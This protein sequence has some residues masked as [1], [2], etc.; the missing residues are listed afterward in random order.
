MAGWPL[1]AGT[2]SGPTTAATDGSSGGAEV[3]RSRSSGWAI[4][5]TYGARAGPSGAAGVPG[6]PATPEPAD[7]ASAIEPAAAADAAASSGDRSA[8]AERSQ[9]PP[10]A[11][12]G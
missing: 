5:E 6:A 3:S 11:A 4:G 2:T 10:G 7:A 8:G 9:P 12:A 1:I